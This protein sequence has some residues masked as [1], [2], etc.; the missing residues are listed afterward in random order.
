MRESRS[1]G[2]VRGAVGN[3]RPYRE[4]V[5]TMSLRVNLRFAGTD[6]KKFQAGL[7]TPRIWFRC[8]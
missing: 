3:S 8:G 7:T 2:S 5:E 1:Y 4:Q 6:G